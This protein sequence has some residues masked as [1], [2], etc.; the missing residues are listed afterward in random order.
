[1]CAV[2]LF[3]FLAFDDRSADSGS[4]H[5][6]TYWVIVSCHILGDLCLIALGD[7]V[8]ILPARRRIRTNFLYRCVRHPVYALYM[9]ADICFVLLTPSLWNVAILTV[10][11]ATFVLRAKLE[12]HI[13]A[14]D[15][16]Y[17]N[18]MANTPFRFIPRLY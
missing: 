12:E 10:G 17:Q 18:Y 15:P 4:G 14:R 6:F 2:S 7:S 9:V 1:M 11:A 5:G 16:A 13:L 8:A 3:Y